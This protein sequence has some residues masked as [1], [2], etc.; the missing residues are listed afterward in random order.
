MFLY[1]VST[2]VFNK[3]L[4]ILMK[5]LMEAL[6]FLHFLDRSSF[7]NRGFS[8]EISLLPM[9]R[10]RNSFNLIGLARRALSFSLDSSWTNGG[11]PFL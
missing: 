2:R 8:F 3:H 6:S 4:L 7:M 11:H 5:L 9:I 1:S 10:N